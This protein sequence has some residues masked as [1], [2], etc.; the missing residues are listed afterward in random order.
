[1]I[2]EI[3]TNEIINKFSDIISISDI[4]HILDIDKNIADMFGN[5]DTFINEQKNEELGHFGRILKPLLNYS[6]ENRKYYNWIIV[7]KKGY[8]KYLIDCVIYFYTYFCKRSDLDLLN[9]IRVS[10][11]K[12]IHWV[13]RI[14]YVIDIYEYIRNKDKNDKEIKKLFDDKEIESVYLYRLYNKELLYEAMFEKKYKK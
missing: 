4:K 3:Q 11:M 8:I 2:M 14:K 1:M 5:Y 7:G 6:I 9:R 12:T 10:L 13:G